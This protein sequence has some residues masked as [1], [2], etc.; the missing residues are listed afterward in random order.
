MASAPCANRN[1]YELFADC[2]AADLDPTKALAKRRSLCKAARSCHAERQLWGL[3]PAARRT[4][5]QH[6]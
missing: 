5:R 6:G 4:G 3:S 1:H 2:F